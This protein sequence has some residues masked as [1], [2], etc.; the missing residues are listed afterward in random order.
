MCVCAT[1]IGDVR[2]TVRAPA[3]ALL[4]YTRK[5]CA[6]PKSELRRVPAW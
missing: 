6:L 4:R 5:L 3:R 1:C 2:H